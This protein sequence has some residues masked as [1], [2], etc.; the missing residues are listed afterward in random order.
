MTKPILI[1]HEGNVY[2]AV[3]YTIDDVWAATMVYNAR[4][5]SQ[6]EYD[7]RDRER[8]R[9]LKAYVKNGIYKL[10]LHHFGGV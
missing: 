3:P 4:E 5:T 8:I 10:K 1:E 2:E 9:K 7:E 6:P